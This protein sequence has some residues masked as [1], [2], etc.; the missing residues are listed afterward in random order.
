MQARCYLAIGL[1]TVSCSTV[2]HGQTESGSRFPRVADGTYEISIC[3]GDCAKDEKKVSGQ[4]IVDRSKRSFPGKDEITQ[5]VLEYS[6]TGQ[7]PNYCYFF[8]PGNTV[9]EES[10]FGSDP[11]NFGELTTKADHPEV[12]PFYLNSPDFRL[13]TE[14]Q[15][16]DTGGFVGDWSSAY[17]LDG[18]VEHVEY[19]MEGARVAPPDASVCY[20]AIP[21]YRENDMKS[22]CLAYPE[23]CR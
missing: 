1:L 4:L 5:F 21:I 18:K 8:D 16:A 2:V 14:I 22:Y 19:H 17:A 9:N 10:M 12:I 11:V 7:S 15:R 13:W 20:Q 6:V 3:K 23:K